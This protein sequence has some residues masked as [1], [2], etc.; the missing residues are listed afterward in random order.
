MHA[1][2]LAVCLILAGATHRISWAKGPVS[3]EAAIALLK[4]TTASEMDAAL[5]R[6]PFAAWIAEKFSDWKVRWEASDCGTPSSE[7][8]SDAAREASDCVQVDIMQ[9]AQKEHGTASRGYHLVFQVAT[10][11]KGLMAVPKLRSATRQEDD[12]SEDLKD[13]S[14]VEP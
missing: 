10:T 4:R 14:E 12:D 1:G 2:K 3:E 5:P 8:K 7:A 11:K 6:R 13:L 9:P